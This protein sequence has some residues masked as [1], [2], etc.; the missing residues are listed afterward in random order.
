MSNPVH[1][2]DQIEK[3][4]QATTPLKDSAI[5]TGKLSTELR[6]LKKTFKLMDIPISSGPAPAQELGTSWLATF[7]SST[8]MATV[9]NNNQLILKSNRQ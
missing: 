3:Q 6:D 2:L 7:L 9:R 1:T 4:Q 8:N 5:V